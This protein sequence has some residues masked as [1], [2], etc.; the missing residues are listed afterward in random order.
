MYPK[1]FNQIRFGPVEW[2]R[3]IRDQSFS[4]SHPDSACMMHSHPNGI[5]RLVNVAK[6][7]FRLGAVL[8]AFVWFPLLMVTSQPVF[9]LPGEDTGPP[10]VVLRHIQRLMDEGDAY[11]A[12]SELLRLVHLYP[13]HRS[14]PWLELARARLYY[15]D[16]RYQQ[17][18]LMLL[19]LRDRFPKGKAADGAARLLAFGQVRQG[20]YAQARE[21]LEGLDGFTPDQAELSELAIA[22]PGTAPPGTVPPETAKAWST[23]LPGAGFLVLGETAKGLGAM[24]VNLVLLGG[25]VASTQQGNQGAAL[26]LLLAELAFYQGGRQAAYESAQSLQHQAQQRR[27]AQWLERQEESRWLGLGL[28]IRWK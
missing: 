13:K 27:V 18:E 14:R 2:K 22:P 16:G 7:D 26:L 15:Q 1:R 17:A 11:R 19:S 9:G 23:W 12:E 25:A 8:S 28:E 6:S 24:A 3:K 20:R 21:L 5:D 4:L 10:P